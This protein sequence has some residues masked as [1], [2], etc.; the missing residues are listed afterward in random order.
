MMT[1]YDILIFVASQTSFGWVKNL[2]FDLVFLNTYYNEKTWY[3][4]IKHKLVGKYGEILSIPCILLYFVFFLISLFIF[5]LK[6]ITF[7][8]LWF[9]TIPAMY[10]PHI[11]PIDE[12]LSCPECRRQRQKRSRLER[13]I[14][15]LKK[16]IE[17]KD[18]EMKSLNRWIDILEAKLRILKKQLPKGTATISKEGSTKWIRNAKKWTTGFI[19]HFDSN[20]Y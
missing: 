8:T 12:T 17:A 14:V 19:I 13:F 7:V 10:P 1:R 4:T 11:I 9:I 16:H 2:N 20:V 3:D 18:K 15:R 6:W 5:T